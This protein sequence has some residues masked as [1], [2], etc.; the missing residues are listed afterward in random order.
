MKDL[1]LK[2]IGR[3]RGVEGGSQLNLEGLPLYL[4]VLSAEHL[5]VHCIRLQLGQVVLLMHLL[6]LCLELSC[7][8]L[9][10]LRLAFTTGLWFLSSLV[11]AFEDFDD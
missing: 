2:G 3:V 5:L 7:L 4:E 9:F 11:D 1:D 8:R 6:L 10:D